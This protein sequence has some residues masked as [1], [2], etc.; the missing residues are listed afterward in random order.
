[1]KLYQSEYHGVISNPE[2]TLE[3]TFLAEI[4]LDKAY[5]LIKWCQEKLGYFEDPTGK[6]IFSEDEAD[7]LH[8]NYGRLVMYSEDIHE[9]MI[10][11]YMIIAA[12][13][14]DEADE[15]AEFESWEHILELTGEESLNGED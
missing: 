1:M 9:G 3:E 4:S 11:Q 13:S 2:D 14:I 10:H 6:I 15:I 8:Q 12:E 7:L 5:E